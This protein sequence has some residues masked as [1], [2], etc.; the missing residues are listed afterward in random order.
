MAFLESIGILCWRHRGAGGFLD[1]VR[2]VDGQ[3]Y[4]DDD[5][6]VEDLLHE[7]GHVAVVPKPYR[8]FATD[9]LEVVTRLMGKAMEDDLCQV[10]SRLMRAMMQSGEA[11]AT[12][13]A[14]AAGKHLGIPAELIISDGSYNGEG[15]AIRLQLQMRAYVGING[16]WHAEMCARPHQKELP[17]YPAL[18]HWTQ[19][20]GLDEGDLVSPYAKLVT[21]H[22][23]ARPA[24]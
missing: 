5:A 2:I 6:A 1:R 16:L 24:A 21:Q 13:W 17:Q 8:K 10:D 9:D 22:D 4:F 14:W 7:A 15:A 18:L 19:D 3:I 20:I 11:E 23:R 12:A